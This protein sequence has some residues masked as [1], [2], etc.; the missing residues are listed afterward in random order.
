MDASLEPRYY[1]PPVGD[2]ER[3][4][5]NYDE[6]SSGSGNLYVTEGAIDALS[7]G[8]ATA[9]SDS[10]VS[11]WKFAELRKAAERG[12]KIIFVIDKNKVGYDLGQAALKEGWSVVVMP[13]GVDD[14]NRCRIRFGRLW[15]L[16]Y[17][18][19]THAAGVAGEVMLRMK[20]DRTDKNRKTKAHER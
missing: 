13:D 5:F 12:R 1:N 4:M 8:P 7:I 14:A 2:K 9:L 17:L 18:A 15:L 20:C 10:H 11:E 3:I 6:L 19:T 16:N